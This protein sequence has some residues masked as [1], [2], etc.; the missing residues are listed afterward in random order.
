MAEYRE[1]QTSDLMEVLNLRLRDSDIREMD[2]FVGE[3]PKEALVNLLIV[4][5]KLFVIEDDNEE[6]VGVF[7]Y[8]KYLPP[9]DNKGAEVYFVA[10]DKLRNISRIKFLRSSKEI[11]EK[12]LQET[13]RL[14]NFVS[15]E[16]LASIKWLKWLGFDVEEN[17]PINFENPDVPF[18]RFSMEVKG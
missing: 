7:G 18:Y 14:E 3:N 12:M 1:F 16:N 5:D 15:S 13:N 11:V 17:E 8:S 9:N 4:A 2:D 6:I 10:S